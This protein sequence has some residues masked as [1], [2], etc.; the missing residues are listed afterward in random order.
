MKVL[1]D[2]L[3][4]NENL[5]FNRCIVNR[6]YDRE[7]KDKRPVMYVYIDSDEIGKKFYVPNNEGDFLEL[8]EEEFIKKYECY[9]IDKEKNNRT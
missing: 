3:L 1:S 2:V 8:E 4:D 7:D 5:D 9:E 6:V